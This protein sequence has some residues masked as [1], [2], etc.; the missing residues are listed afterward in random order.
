[1]DRTPGLYYQPSGLRTTLMLERNP[2]EDLWA[3]CTQPQ[4]ACASR[5]LAADLCG[6]YGCCRCGV[7]WFVFF[8]QGTLQIFSG[9]HFRTFDGLD[10]PAQSVIR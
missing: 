9:A 1:M 3:P 4:A 5:R 6:L 10:E 2:T 7:L 8:T